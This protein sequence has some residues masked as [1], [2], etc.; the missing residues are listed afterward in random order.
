MYLHITAMYAQTLLY[1][2]CITTGYL[3]QLCNYSRMF[4]SCTLNCKQT[5]LYIYTYV[6]SVYTVVVY[7]S[8]QLFSY[9]IAI[10]YITLNFL[11]TS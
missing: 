10:G 4:D 6:H 11:P 7:Y 1:K 9:L 3:Y 8:E 2:A 5:F